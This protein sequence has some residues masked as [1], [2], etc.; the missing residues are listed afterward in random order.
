MKFSPAENAPVY[1]YIACG[2]LLIAETTCVYFETAFMW[3]SVYN[4][5]LPSL[6][7][8]TQTMG[9]GS[10]KLQIEM[11]LQKIQKQG[12]DENMQEDY[13]LQWNY[14]CMVETRRLPTFTAYTADIG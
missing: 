6:K 1:I 10:A 7:K 9:K 14:M 8:T 4:P 5:L 3:M 11:D 2:C 12:R 13:T